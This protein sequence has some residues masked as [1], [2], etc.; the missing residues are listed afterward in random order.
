MYNC[1]NV[2]LKWT[3]LDKIEPGR[4]RENAF[5]KL[6]YLEHPWSSNVPEN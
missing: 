1:H 2:K 3:K 4:K 5:E 6:F